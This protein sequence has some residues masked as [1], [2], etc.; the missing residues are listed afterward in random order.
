M[1]QNKLRL[2]DNSKVGIYLGY[3]I[4]T[5]KWTRIVSVIRLPHMNY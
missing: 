2:R 4:L 1:K 3:N 5:S